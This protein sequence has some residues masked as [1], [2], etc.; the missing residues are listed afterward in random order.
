M[1]TMSLKS[2]FSKVEKNFLGQCDCLA[3]HKFPS[4]SQFFSN[5]SFFYNMKCLSLLQEIPLA[6]TTSLKNTLKENGGLSKPTKTKRQKEHFWVVQKTK[7]YDLE[8][9]DLENDNLEKDDLENDDL[10]KDD[11]ENDDL[12]NDDLENDDLEN[13]DLENDDLENDDLEKK[14]PVKGGGGGQA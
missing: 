11:L 8:S 6:T 5:F 4:K 10:E 13:N 9:D 7:T 3:W 14:T 1:L 2:K 12:E